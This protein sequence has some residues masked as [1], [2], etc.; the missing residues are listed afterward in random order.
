[1]KTYKSNLPEI[2]LRMKNSGIAKCKISCSRDVADFF[3]MIFDS[4]TL[5]IYESMFAVFLNRSNNTIGFFRVSQGGLS[6]TVIDIRLVLKTALESLAHSIIICHN[7]PSGNIQPSDADRQ[8]TSKLK[9][10]A[11]LMDIQ[12]LDHVV[13]TSDSYFS[14]SDEGLI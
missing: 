10:A 14:F 2:S 13:L 1:M 8:I 11:A 5:E 3:R 12:I 7:H 6:G 9:Q 4:E